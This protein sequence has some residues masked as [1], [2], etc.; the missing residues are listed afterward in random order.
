MRKGKKSYSF[1]FG[2][3]NGLNINNFK[4]LLQ[5]FRVVDTNVWTNEVLKHEYD[6]Y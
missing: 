4:E 3:G 2:L 6:L 5:L 1:A